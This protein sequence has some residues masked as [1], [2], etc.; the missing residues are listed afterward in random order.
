MTGYL[1]PAGLEEELKA[2]LQGPIEQFGRLFLVPGAPQKVYWAQNIWYDPVRVSFRSI[3]DGP[4]SCAPFTRS[5][6]FIPID[7]SAG[8][9]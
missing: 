4:G 9:F 7:R 5:G 1:A 6:P 3:S 8:A 2:E